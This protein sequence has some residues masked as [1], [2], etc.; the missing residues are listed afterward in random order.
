[1]NKYFLFF[2]FTI[3]RFFDLIT[4]YLATNDLSY[5]TSPLIIYLNMDWF[6][7]I[8]SNIIFVII[9]FILLVY[10][11]QSNII[12]LE[13][14][15]ENKILSLT[16]YY[17]YIIL[18]LKRPETNMSLF[19]LLKAKINVSAFVFF[20]TRGLTLTFTL[21]STVVSLNNILQHNKLYLLEGHPFV[22]FNILFLINIVLFIL[23]FHFFV[24]QRF[25]NIQ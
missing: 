1:M 17:K 20:A 9:I 4:T 2:L 8:L 12:Y 19:Q 7:L 11:K 23:S 15:Y 13:E 18:K 14:K 21:I 16:D 5:E 10:I 24:K 3:T 25:K 6:G 22:I